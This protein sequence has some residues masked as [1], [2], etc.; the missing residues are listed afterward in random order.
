MAERPRLALVRNDR[1]WNGSGLNQG[2]G[3]WIN[4]R[5]SRVVFDAYATHP[6]QVGELC[7]R[8]LGS[9]V[10]LLVV[11]NNLYGSHICGEGGEYE[12]L[13]LDSPLFKQKIIL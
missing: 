2:S 13:T 4:T 11:Q 8:G 5:A 6:D 9:D 1:C 3:N 12:T 10:G 7:L